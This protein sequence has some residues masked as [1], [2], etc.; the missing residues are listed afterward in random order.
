MFFLTLFFWVHSTSWSPFPVTSHW[1]EHVLGTPFCFLQ[2]HHLNTILI[3]CNPQGFPGVAGTPSRAHSQSGHHSRGRTRDRYNLLLTGG[4]TKCL[5]AQVCL[6]LS[7]LEVGL[8]VSRF[9]L[10]QMCTLLLCFREETTFLGDTVLLRIDQTWVWLKRGGRKPKHFA[11]L[12]DTWWG[13]CNF[14]F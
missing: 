4:C 2:R 1:H 6:D 14:P 8:S 12:L 3:L 13:K 7:P 11:T 5:W 10:E 9:V